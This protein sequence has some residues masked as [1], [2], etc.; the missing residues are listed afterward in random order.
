MGGN[1][2]KGVYEVC[3]RA[4]AREQLAF[5]HLGQQREHGGSGCPVFRYG[6]AGHE[7]RVEMCL[8]ACQ[9]SG[10]TQYKSVRLTI[11]QAGLQAVHH[12]AA[13]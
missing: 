8:A 12:T 13:L 6:G 3:M 4:R 9:C 1:R 10:R 7:R 11:Q 2:P 5:A